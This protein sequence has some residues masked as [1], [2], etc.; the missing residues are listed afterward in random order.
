M[1]TSW[2]WI[3][4]LCACLI[5]A[6]AAWQRHSSGRKPEGAQPLPVEGAVS[7]AKKAPHQAKLRFTKPIAHDSWAG[8]ATQSVVAVVAGVGESNLNYLARMTALQNL[9]AVISTNDVAALRTWL[10]MHYNPSN[11]VSLLEFNAVKNSAV[12]LLLR[13]PVGAPELIADL[14]AMFYDTSY[15]PVWRDYCL[16]F[17]AGSLET[18]SAATEPAVVELCS[19]VR[20]VLREATG[21]RTDTIAGTALLGL[22]AE[23]R[24]NPDAVKPAEVNVLASAVAR[25]AAASEACRITALR[26]AGMTGAADVLPVARE[27]SQIGGTET[28]RQAAIATVG[29]LGG[30]SEQE[31]LDSLAHDSD[32]AVA[33][34]AQQAG[35]ALRKRLGAGPD[36]PADV[37]AMP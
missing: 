29:E 33:A 15:D 14:A 9:P 20:D 4:L 26:V 19:D 35:A 32:K 37:K 13:Q 18:F 25:D 23:A 24:R 31:L 3:V 27:L 12:D 11:G 16:Q 10:T 17:M 34:I 6:W 36:S 21:I 30:A 8:V 2:R 28:I 5:V 1:R 22:N 7:V